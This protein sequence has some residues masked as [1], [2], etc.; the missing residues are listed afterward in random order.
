[1]AARQSERPLFNISVHSSIGSSGMLPYSLLHYVNAPE[2]NSF[3]SHPRLQ[4]LTV[5][6][7]HT[8][9][10]DL[11]GIFSARNSIIATRKVRSTPFSYWGNGVC[12]HHACLLGQWENTPSMSSKVASDEGRKLF[13]FHAVLDTY[14]RQLC[15]S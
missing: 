13:L 10:P 6:L 11:G 15:Q 9:M 4:N 2:I 7:L 14:C 3:L 12:L 5:K 8:T 1:M